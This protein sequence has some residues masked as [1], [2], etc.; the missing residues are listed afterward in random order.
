[1]VKEID[2][3]STAVK[4]ARARTKWTISHETR[5]AVHSCLILLQQCLESQHHNRI[6]TTY[7]H[8]VQCQGLLFFYVFLLFV[9][10]F[11][12]IDGSAT[13]HCKLA[14]RFVLSIFFFVLVVYSCTRPVNFTG[15]SNS[16]FL[17]NKIAPNHITW[18]WAHVAAPPMTVREKK[19]RDPVSSIHVTSL[20]FVLHKRCCPFICISHFFTEAFLSLS[21][22]TVSLLV[23]LRCFF[24]FFLPFE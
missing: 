5:L 11:A 15:L 7:G 23:A 12:L 17:Y 24:S 20:R 10:L 2:C 9:Y 4:E 14:S 19:G 8:Q 22:I 18:S 6:W 1:M 16:L 3:F 13:E 21:H